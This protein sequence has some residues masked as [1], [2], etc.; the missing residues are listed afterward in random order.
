[1]KRIIMFKGGVEQ[2]IRNILVQ[3][4]FIKEQL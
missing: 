4:A 2:G 1:M 3:P